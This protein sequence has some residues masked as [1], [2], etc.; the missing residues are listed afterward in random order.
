VLL[1]HWRP[2][3]E[4]THIMAFTGNARSLYNTYKINN[5]YV[6]MGRIS[7][8]MTLFTKAIMAQIFGIFSFVESTIAAVTRVRLSDIPV[9]KAF[10]IRR[11]D[12]YF[13]SLF[14][15]SFLFIPFITF[16]FPPFCDLS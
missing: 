2:S 10:K 1:G 15:T 9:G 11:G 16:L 6:Y 8:K 5:K 14:L 13:V 4:D 12:F 3:V 7:L